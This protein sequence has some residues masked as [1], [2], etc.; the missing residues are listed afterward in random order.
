MLLAT[1]TT[2]EQTGGASTVALATANL[3]AHAHT[4]PSHNHT[5]NHD[6]AQATTSSAGTHSHGL[7]YTAFSIATGS[8]AWLPKRAQDGGSVV[9]G[10]NDAGAH[11]HTLN[12]P[13]F[14]GN[15]GTA[16]AVPTANTG[17][18]TPVNIMPPYITTYMWK[19]TA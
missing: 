15:S 7:Y 18:G 12:L 14:T 6:H 11:T 2:A 19:R 1:D 5:I 4:V 10:T 16:A 17:S 9:E 3:P 8:G 13:S